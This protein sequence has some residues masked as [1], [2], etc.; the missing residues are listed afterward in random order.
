MVYLQFVA[1]LLTATC[2]VVKSWK[3]KMEGKKKPFPQGLTPALVY[4]IFPAFYTVLGLLAH[5]GGCSSPCFLWETTPKHNP[6]H[7]QEALLNIR[8]QCSFSLNSALPVSLML[9]PSEMAPLL[10]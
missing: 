4:P 5:T 10:L 2:N 9:L 6:S 1:G 3:V 8:A 7:L